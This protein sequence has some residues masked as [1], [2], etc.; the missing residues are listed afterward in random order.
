LRT[1]VDIGAVVDVEDVHGAAVLIYPVDDPVGSATG[2]KATGE[3]AEKR[4]A[5]P[6]RVRCER[7]IA[8]LQY[9]RGYRLG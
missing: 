9:R 4:L 5:Y 7:G 1:V 8:E 6:V 2:P 3:R